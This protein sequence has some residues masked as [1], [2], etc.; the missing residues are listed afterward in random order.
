M[1]RFDFSAAPPG[2]AGVRPIDP[3]APATA[4][5]RRLAATT[6][7]SKACPIHKRDLEPLPTAPLLYACSACHPALYEE[8]PDA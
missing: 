5:H 7:Y 6:A 2:A 8:T 1:T 4:L 3:H